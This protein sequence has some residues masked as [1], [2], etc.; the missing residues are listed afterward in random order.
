MKLATQPNANVTVTL[1]SDD[2]GAAT[3][4]PAS[5]TFTTTNWSSTQQVTVSGVDDSDTDNE[6]LTVT[7][8]A[9]GGGYGGKTAM[10]SVAVTDNDTAQT[11]PSEPRNLNATSGG[12]TQIDL[13]W[14]APTSNG[15]SAITDYKIEVSTN[16]G[17]VWSNLVANT[18]DSGR[19]YSHTDLS[20]GTTRH[21]RVSAINA[22]GTGDPSNVDGATTDRTVV[23]FGANSYTATEG[24][25]GA[26]VVVRLSHAPA[27]TVTI[28]LTKSH[29]GGATNA[30]HSGIPDDV[31][32]T[33]GEPQRSVTIPL[34]VTHVGGATESDYTGI[35]ASVTFEADQRRVGFRVYGTLDSEI[36][37]GEGL[38]IDFGTPPPGVRVDPRGAYE[39]VEFVDS[40]TAP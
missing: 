7:A 21:Y 16:G 34:V 19:A 22:I 18:S 13:S 30:D 28:P 29:R 27:T 1:S 32:F 6:S 12:R 31:V 37:S 39:T 4:S 20:A 11:V 36:E 35:P 3:V 10:V 24:G 17:S 15:N 40:S 25:S 8:S 14:N 26:T 9:S 2:T 38:R 33:S 23:T 5:L